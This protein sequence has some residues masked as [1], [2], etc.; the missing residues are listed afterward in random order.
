MVEFTP[1]QYN[2]TMY[3]MKKLVI[4]LFVIFVGTS[5][6]AQNKLLCLLNNKTIAYTVDSIDSEY[7]SVTIDIDSC[8]STVLNVPSMYYRESDSIIIKIRKK[9]S[10][11]NNNIQTFYCY[12]V[13]PHDIALYLNSDMFPISGENSDVFF[14]SVNL[15]YRDEKMWNCE[16]IPATTKKNDGQNPR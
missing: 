8:T 4:Y 15:F 13:G 14:Y 2:K 10:D 16:L 1:F 12:S 11:V 3:N 6:Y 9:S 5:L 7:F